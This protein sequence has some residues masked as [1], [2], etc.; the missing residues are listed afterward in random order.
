M[1]TLMNF[2]RAIM[3]WL[4]HNYQRHALRRAVKQAYVEFSRSYP[5]AVAVLFDA[6]FVKTH[7]LPMLIRAAGEGDS[8]SATEVAELWAR[9]VSMLP[10]LRQQHTAAMIPAATHF[11]CM[12]GDGLIEMEIGRNANVLPLHVLTET[13]VG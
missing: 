10:R 3:R 12:V 11:L 9:Q 6:Y 5:E 13:A 8:V 4:M 7:V 1:D 2:E